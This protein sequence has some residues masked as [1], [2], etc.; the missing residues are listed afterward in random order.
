MSVSGDARFSFGG[1]LG[2]QLDRLTVDGFS[3]LGHGITLPPQI[4]VVPP[5]ATLV[6]PYSND[7]VDVATLN[8][9]HY[10]DVRFTDQSGAGLNLSSITDAT[11]ELT[12]TGTAAAGVVLSGAPTQVD[13]TNDPGL[14]RYAFTGSFTA[15]T[16]GYDT[17]GFQF[18]ASSFADA[19]GT[20]NAA[21]SGQFYVYTDPPANPN[22]PV[23]P[24]VQLASPMNGATIGSTTFGA[25][26]YI[27]IS[28][29]PGVTGGVVSLL[30]G[31]QITLSGAG[32]AHLVSTIGVTAC[33]AV[34]TSKTTYR[35]TLT[36]AN[37]Y[38]TSTM[39]TGLPAER[40]RDRRRGRRRRVA[41][42]R[43]GRRQ[44]DR[45]RLGQRPLHRLDLRPERGLDERRRSRSG[46]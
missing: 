10:L 12:L 1:G 7:I 22:A 32:A 23:V 33:A 6:D 29:N 45:G 9:N 4:V 41:G 28:F 21:S 40:R 11:A 36:P 35:C 14:F 44:P 25:R 17:V 19:H 31:F 16:S 42:H 24:T 8:A 38:T 34:A 37:G 26:P 13:P 39:F 3:I 46:R 18:A 20:T 27:D 43:A 5:T 30:P 2:F 15:P